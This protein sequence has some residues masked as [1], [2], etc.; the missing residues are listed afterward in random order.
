MARPNALETDRYYLPTAELYETS[1]NFGNVTPAF[2]NNYDVWINFGKANNLRQFLNQSGFYDIVGGNSNPGDYLALFCSEAVLPGSN[3]EFQEVK[4]LRQGVQQNYATFRSYPE[5]VLTWYSQVDYYTN[6]VFNQWL[7]FISPTRMGSGHGRSTRERRNQSA[8]YRRLQY[9]A[10]Y[11]VDMEVTAFSKAIASPRN[12]LREQTRWTVREPSSITYYLENIF[13]VNII[14]APLAYGTAELIKTSVTFKYDYFYIDRTSRRGDFARRSDTSGDVRGSGG[15]T[16]PKPV[17][18]ASD[19][20]S[21]PP[22][23]I[24]VETLKDEKNLNGNPLID[25]NGYLNYS[26]SGDLDKIMDF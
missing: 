15:T 18:A 22:K 17:A 3:I 8:S 16:L 6:E 5:V 10:E 12:A 11:K 1:T 25:E 20:Q 7:E 23:S 21:V 2:N 19:L 24:T 4:G 9:P 14:A 13:P 26:G